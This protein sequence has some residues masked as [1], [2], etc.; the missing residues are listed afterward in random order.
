MGGGKRG[1]EETGRKGKTEILRKTEG[2]ETNPGGEF[3]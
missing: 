2:A 3:L 1:G